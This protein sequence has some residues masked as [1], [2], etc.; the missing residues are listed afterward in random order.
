MIACQNGPEPLTPRQMIVVENSLSAMEAAIEYLL[1]LDQ[2]LTK[3]SLFQNLVRSAQS[4]L[5][6]QKKLLQEALTL[7]LQIKLLLLN[8]PPKEEKA[9]SMTLAKNQK[10]S[11]CRKKSSPRCSKGSFSSH[12]SKSQ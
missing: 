6:W 12:G 10:P 8:L 11:T 4:H 1:V 5:T 3:D 2:E 7:S 9:I